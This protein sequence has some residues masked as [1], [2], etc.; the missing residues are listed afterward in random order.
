MCSGNPAPS[1]ALV[2]G[3][4]RP[5]RMQKFHFLK[6]KLVK[7]KFFLGLPLAL[8]S[9]EIYLG[10]VLGYF[11]TKFF[12]GKIPSLAFNIGKWKFHFHH[13]LYGLAILISALYFNF[14]PF[15]QLAFGFLG[16]MI[17][18]GIYCHSDWYKIL[19]KRK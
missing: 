16:G 10:A 12:T 11:S 13:W 1:F 5:P 9:L 14:L 8:F 15:P 7:P 4:S 19:M 6:P 18:Q 3:E 2:R 17:F